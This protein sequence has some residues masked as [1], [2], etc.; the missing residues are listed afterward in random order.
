MNE[1]RRS[2]VNRFPFGILYSV[3]NDQI[4]IL[5]VMHLHKEPGYWKKRK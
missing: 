2:L 4:Y 3:Q 5:A 1:F